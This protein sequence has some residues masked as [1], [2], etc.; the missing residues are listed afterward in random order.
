[1]VILRLY[2]LV[3]SISMESEI[4]GTSQLFTRHCLHESR[5]LS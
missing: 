5:F 2:D 1:M 4:T 3:S